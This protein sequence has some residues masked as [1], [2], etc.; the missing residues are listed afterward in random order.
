MKVRT[1][2]L[3]IKADDYDGLEEAFKYSKYIVPVNDF[4][5]KYDAELTIRSSENRTC[6]WS[7]YY[8]WIFGEAIGKFSLNADDI[9]EFVK[10]FEEYQAIASEAE[11]DE[12]K[13]YLRLK[14]KW[15]DKEE[16]FNKYNKV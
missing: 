9:P 5:R 12:Y 8:A 11:S 14:D 1:E 15:K 16:L 2:D 4:L 3:I 7:P 13:E 6:G 10:H